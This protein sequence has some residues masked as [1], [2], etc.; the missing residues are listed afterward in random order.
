[1]EGVSKMQQSGRIP[2]PA[3]KI[4]LGKE[5]GKEGGWEEHPVAQGMVFL[6]GKWP[7]GHKIPKRAPKLLPQPPLSVSLLRQQLQGT[8][9]GHCG[10][11]G[12]LC[13][14]CTGMAGL[15]G[16]CLRGGTSAW[17]QKM[18]SHPQPHPG[19]KMGLSEQELGTS[20]GNFSELC[21]FRVSIPDPQALSFPTSTS[22]AALTM[23]QI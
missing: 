23:S 7:Q 13:P 10:F 20:K 16:G 1:M 9:W 8:L 19:T 6:W 15:D 11:V 22:S 18:L 17:L 5:G 21:R 4:Q 3:M 14:S 2:A 12:T